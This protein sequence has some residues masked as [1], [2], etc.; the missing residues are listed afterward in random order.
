VLAN[1]LPSLAPYAWPIAKNVML[2]WPERFVPEESS[3]KEILMQ[4][5]SALWTFTCFGLLFECIFLVMNAGKR[6]K[7]TLSSTELVLLAGFMMNHLPYYFIHRPMYL[8]HYFPSL[9]LLLLL[10]PFV[11]PR[12]VRC[13][14]LV[15]RDALFARVFIACAALL[16]FVSFTMSVRT[17]YGV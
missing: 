8:Y 14:A 7:I 1:T 3:G 6:R 4:G 12:I 16:V 2:F 5:N 15:T 9:L 10:L 13:L 11:T 17:V